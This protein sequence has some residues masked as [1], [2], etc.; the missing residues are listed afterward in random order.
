M[1]YHPEP[2][3]ELHDLCLQHQYG[4]KYGG[5]NAVAIL[6]DGRFVVFG[7][8]HEGILGV[9]DTGEELIDLL[10]TSKLWQQ[11]VAEQLT[12]RLARKPKRLATRRGPSPTTPP[13]KLNLDF[14][15]LRI[16]TSND[17]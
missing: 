11:L 8:L 7:K 5:S 14:T 9:A 1:I 15:S 16:G 17:S 6:P 12:A 2:R 3:T 13:V 10:Q 4:K